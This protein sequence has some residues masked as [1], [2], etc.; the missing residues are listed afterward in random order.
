M[1]AYERGLREDLKRAELEV[2][3]IK[4]L[5]S[6]IIP[7]REVISNFESAI[8]GCT[9]TKTLRKK[10]KRIHSAAESQEESNAEVGNLLDKLITVLNQ[11]TAFGQLGEMEINEAMDAVAD[12][13]AREYLR[14]REVIAY[15]V[16][17]V[18]RL[19]SAQES[20]LLRKSAAY[21]TS[22][23]KEYVNERLSFAKGLI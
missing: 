2:D 17:K 10:I 14:D 16:K 15:F 11:A 20:R 6:Q 9:L 13:K 1:D 3:R 7:Y 23:V 21:G 22:G 12:G 5:I 4:M 8:N 18:G 19:P